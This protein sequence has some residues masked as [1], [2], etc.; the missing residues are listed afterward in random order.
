MKYNGDGWVVDGKRN[1]FVNGE[2]IL[3]VLVCCRSSD[4]V[5]PWLLLLSNGSW[6]KVDNCFGGQG[7]MHDFC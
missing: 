4:G 6:L 2:S 1:E 5:I 3:Y 7:L